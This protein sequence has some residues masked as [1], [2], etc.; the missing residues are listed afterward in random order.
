MTP[1]EDVVGA[2]TRP[3]RLAWN[4]LWRLARAVAL[5]LLSL[6]SV[7]VCA[8]ILGISQWGLLAL[9]QAVLAPLGVLDLGIG[10]ATVK[11]V[12]E[13]IGR[14]DPAEAKRVVHTTVVFNIATGL[15]GL[16]VLS[17]S[18][19]WLATFAFIIPP[20]QQATAILGFRLAGLSWLVNAFGNTYMGVVAAHQRYDRQAL[21]AIVSSAAGAIGTIVA[22]LAGGGVVAV[23]VVQV[24]VNGTTALVWL[25]SA[26]QLLPAVASLPRPDAATFRRSFSFGIWQSVGMAGGL[27]AQ[28]S[29]RYLLG[30]TFTAAVVGF[31]AL[32]R[33][34]QNRLYAVFHDMGEVIFPAVSQRQGSGDLSGARESALRAGWT[35]SMLFGTATAV[36]GTLGGDFLGLWI[37]AETAEAATGVLRLLCV[38]GLIGM[39]I[40]G[41]Y[42][43]TLGTGRTQ[44]LAASSVV[45]GL[46]VIAAGL[47]LVP[48]FGLA[49]VGYGM[50]AGAASQWI[51]LHVIWRRGFAEDVTLREFALHV[52]VPPLLFVATLVVL[53]A[54]H[55]AIAHRPS[56]P[57]LVLE[58]VVALPAS[59]GLG[60]GL[61]ELFPGG[62]ARRRALV[63]VVDAA[64]RRLRGTA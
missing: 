7:S 31:Y 24:I 52:Y 8:R 21:V 35:L 30:V 16:G 14:R 5:A 48:R 44:L 54:M 34:L 27:L 56:W 32:A 12:A 13:A 28:W 22:V 40:T 50:I 58:A 55:G 51:V 47:P 6:L 1:E 19:R 36:L 23:V 64:R 42:F 4:A 17:L 57:L 10:T 3:R 2:S 53:S 59:A 60:F 15:A 26:S 37:S 25:W 20:D 39:A 11:F 33:G 45:T 29:D 43:Y 41:P 62:S 63:S 38:E 61:A 49:G 9:F 46:V 18:A